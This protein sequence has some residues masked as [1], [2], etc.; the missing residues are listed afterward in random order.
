MLLDEGRDGGLRLTGG[1]LVSEAHITVSGHPGR[2]LVEELAGGRSYS[3]IFVGDAGAFYSLTAGP[4]STAATA[5]A[6]AFLDS[7]KILPH[8][9][10]SACQ[11]APRKTPSNNEQRTKPAQAMKPRR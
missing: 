10:H 7:F 6:L 4:R 11:G 1:K 2:H 3:R 9:R 8:S 5:K